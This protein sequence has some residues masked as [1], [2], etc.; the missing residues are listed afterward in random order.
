[1]RK[2]LAQ[3]SR[4][5]LMGSLLLVAIFVLPILS[6]AGHKDKLYV[7]DNASGTQDGSANHP[8]K[9]IAQA[10][11]KAD[12]NTEVH[13]L[14]GTYK[15]NIKVPAGVEVFGSNKKNVIIKAK[16]SGEPAVEMNNKTSI[17]NVTIKDGRHGI[18]VGVNDKVSITKCIVENNKKDGIHIKEGSVEEKRKVT[19]S[20]SEI[21]GNGQA[22]IYAEKRRV[23]IV[24]NEIINN[25]SD[26]IDLQKGAKAWVAGN[27]IKSN[28]GSGMKVVLDKSEIW[29][30]NNSFRENKR[31]G[32]EVNAYGIAGKIDINKSKFNDN[33]R[34]AIARILRGSVSP[35]IL[36]G[37]TVQSNNVFS[38]NRIGNISPA[39]RISR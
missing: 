19:I 36:G 38:G 1:M 37:F 5:G 30:K 14:S 28:D 13:I 16:N 33:G 21:K 26:G 29:T 32:V 6:L 9:T 35:A 39:I 8:Y 10:F 3:I 22:G 24:D 4:N 27:R 31:E 17:D 23:V 2:K 12:K 11:K 7:D 20:K 34:Y 18:K 25:D 15:E